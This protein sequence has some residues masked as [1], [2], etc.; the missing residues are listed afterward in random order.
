MAVAKKE[1]EGASRASGG[2]K[3]DFWLF[4]VLFL[5][6]FAVAFFLSAF[7]SQQAKEQYYGGVKFQSDGE[8]QGALKAALG[9]KN[10]VVLSADFGG[11][12]NFS[13]VSEMLTQVALGLGA[14]N[15]NVS[16]GAAG[17][18]T[19]VNGNST[20][21]ACGKA[22]V[23]IS[24]GNCDCVK[25]AGGVVRIEGTDAFLCGNA[26]RVGQL[27]TISLGGRI[28]TSEDAQRIL[29]SYKPQGA[30]NE[31]AENASG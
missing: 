13:C 21:V 23:E 7:W 24:R 1:N 27:I 5:G 17:E 29:G 11:G 16:I 14:S 28:V 19:C 30:G 6:V 15:K 4:V 9:G 20:E 18:S 26:G 22:D 25:M 12:E 10:N 2:G 8:P 3:N 31:S